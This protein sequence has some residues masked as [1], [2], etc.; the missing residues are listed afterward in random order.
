MRLVKW[1][2]ITLLSLSLV[3]T[4]AWWTSPDPKFNPASFEDEPLETG[5][6]PLEQALSLAQFYD[7][8]G[9]TRTLLVTEYDG[10]TVTGLVLNPGPLVPEA[11]PFKVITSW[12]QVELIESA[13]ATTNLRTIA[14]TELLPSGPTGTRHIGSG[15]NFPEHAAEA[16]SDEVFMF[17][18]FGAAT[19]ARTTISAPARGLLDY[20]VELCVRFDRPITKPEDFETAVKGFFLCADFTDRVALVNLADPDNLD[21]GHGFSDAKSGKD[22]YPTGPFIVIPNDWKNFIAHTR[23]TTEI[24]GE[25]R[26]DARGAEMIL[27]FAGLTEKALGDMTKRRFLYQ[28]DYYK[29]VPDNMIHATMTVMSG[30][31]EGVIF[32]P[33]QRHDIIEAALAYLFNGGFLKDESLLDQ[34]KKSFINAEIETGHFLQVGDKVHYRSSTMGEIV[35]NVVE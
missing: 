26:Q 7:E 30:T 34:A 32:T 21:S 23:M 14:V 2:L 22:F 18:K 20:E 3:V 8:T 27:D 12:N 25:P 35:V 28:N 5:I 29:L 4:L 16:S 15:T 10:D 19:P 6:A 17:P 1:T 24:N 13:K 31:S 9:D 33:P 11:D